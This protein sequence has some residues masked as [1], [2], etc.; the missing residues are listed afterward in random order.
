MMVC[1]VRLVRDNALACLVDRAVAVI[2]VSL[3][4]MVSQTARSVTAMRTA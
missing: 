3:V 1:L 4:T 2:S